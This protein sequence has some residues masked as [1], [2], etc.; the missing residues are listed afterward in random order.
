MKKKICIISAFDNWPLRANS[1]MANVFDYFSER[2]YD[3]S[4]IISDFSHAKKT[5]INQDKLPNYVTTINTLP[6]FKNMSFRRIFSHY[7]FSKKVTKVLCAKKPEIVYVIVPP[8]FAAYFCAKYCKKENISCVLDIIDLWPETLPINNTVVK[9]IFNCTVGYGWRWIRNCV[10][11]ETTYIISETNRYAPYLES[12]RKDIHVVFLSKGRKLQKYQSFERKSRKLV[13]GFIGNVNKIINFDSLLYILKHVSTWQIS[14]EIIAS[15]E[16]MNN[17]LFRLEQTNIDYYCYGIVYDEEEKRK[18][19]S[20]WDF[21]Y[22]GQKDSVVTGLSYKSIDYLYYGVPLLN[23]VKSDTWEFVEKKKCG[24]N[25]MNNDRALKQLVISIDKLT[26]E[27]LIAMKKASIETF[28]T[29]LS[30]NIYEK[31]M[32]DIFEK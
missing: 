15:G 11:K 6:Y 12:E 27:D 10:L 32:D 2:K 13:I 24:F 8:N 30:W 17:L 21:G 20:G 5:K 29:F 9:H 7:D 3:V 28:N 1:R 26:D 19:M 31:K 4:I 23:S 16:G 14:F 25:F 18:I 22:N